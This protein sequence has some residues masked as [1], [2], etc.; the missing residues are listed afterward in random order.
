M[1]LI[2]SLFSP[3]GTVYGQVLKIGGAGMAY[4]ISDTEPKSKK[5]MWVDS[6]NGNLLKVYDKSTGTWIPVNSAWA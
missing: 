1:A 4:V 6:G 2:S 5:V 3:P